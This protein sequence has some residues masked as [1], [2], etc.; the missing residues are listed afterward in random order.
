MSNFSGQYFLLWSKSKNDFHIEPVEHTLSVNSRCYRD[1]ESIHDD[2]IP[3][4]IGTQADISA[5][6]ESCRKSTLVRRKK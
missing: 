5:S 2:Y 6:A 1:D 3:I 4:A